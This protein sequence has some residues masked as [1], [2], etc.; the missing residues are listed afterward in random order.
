MDFLSFK[1]IVQIQN[2]LQKKN[3]DL[4]VTCKK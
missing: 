1:E 4:F 2:Y 3:R